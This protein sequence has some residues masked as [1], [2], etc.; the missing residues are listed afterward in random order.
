MS[1][2]TLCTH[3]IVKDTIDSLDEVCT[4]KVT[5][6]L[7][8]SEAAQSGCRVHIAE[9]Y[10]PPRMTKIAKKLGY[11]G[12][13]AMDLTTEDESGKKWDLSNREM[14]TKAEMREIQMKAELKAMQTKAETEKRLQ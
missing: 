2:G 8:K 11:N 5:K 1:G 13:F 6:K 3:K 10:S 9:A 4:R 12:G 7:S 14:Q